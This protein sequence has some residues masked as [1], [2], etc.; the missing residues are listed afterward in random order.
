[1]RRTFDVIVIGSGISG[2]SSAIILREKGLN[3][4]V[5]TKEK[6]IAETNTNLAQGGIIAKKSGDSF[7]RLRDDI[8][9]A[10]GGYNR[11][12]AVELLA[13][14]G[15]DFVFDFLID[16]IGV[17]F[18]KNASG[19]LDYTEE[20]AHSK[21]RVL[22][23]ED[24]T[25]DKIERKLI[26]YCQKV[27]VKILTEFT[28]VDLITN[29]HHSDDIQELYEEREVMGIYALNNVNG[30]VY[31]FF[32]HQVI[33]ATGGIGNL[34]QHT[35]NLPSATGDGLSM[36][37][38]AG[39]EIINAEF[40][41]FHPTSFFHKDI[42]RFLI[43]ESLRGEGARLFN[44]KS[45]EFM[46]NYAPDLKDLAPRDVVSRAIY[47]EMGKVGTEYMFLEIASFYQGSEPLKKRF[48]KIYETCLKGGINILKEAIPIVPAAHYFCGGVKVDLQGRSSLKNLYAIGE[49]SC[50]G[51]HG[52]NRLASTSLLEGLLWAKFSADDIAENNSKIAENRFAKIPNWKE[53][54]HIEDF[55]SLLLVQDWKAIQMTMWN[56][57][58]IIRTQKGLIRAKADLEYYSHRIFKFYKTAR[59]D[60]NII[61]LRNAVINASIIVNA[62]L[63]NTKSSGCHFVK[64]L[65]NY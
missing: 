11:I 21:R 37:Y 43:S 13:E 25:G 32:S 39:A 36:A 3:V 27:G 44:Q 48:S 54:Q 64:E 62:A 59:L 47:E 65:S 30:E 46:M 26:A 38:R 8:L 6:E 22:H 19:K 24:R 49:V 42:K 2:L 53:P 57:A 5:V 34:Y 15:P 14:K 56:Y 52:A 40:I 20:A 41:Q 31:T 29:E 28:A 63:R 4:V 12:D 60:K 33:L 61:E 1:M 7:A 9:K 58:G 23:Y 16:K 17:D 50:T 55:D 10:G 18:S 35:T 45:E 51:V